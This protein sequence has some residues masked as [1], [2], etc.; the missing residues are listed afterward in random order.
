MY[1]AVRVLTVV[2]WKEVIKSAPKLVE[3]A[4]KILE[5]RSKEK[6]DRDA[7]SDIL[8]LEHVGASVDMLK[9]D[10]HHINIDATEQADL[11]S[12]LAAQVEALSRGLEEMTSSLRLQKILLIGFAALSA[13]AVLL[14]VVI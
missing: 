10:L 13:V 4:R 8:T 9:S 3:S 5:R 11:A 7:P 12:Q 6:E 2:P 1:Q 14:A